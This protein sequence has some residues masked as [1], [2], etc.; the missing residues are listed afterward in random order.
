[1]IDKFLSVNPGLL[2]GLNKRMGKILMEMDLF[3]GM[4]VDIEVVW[5]G[6]AYIQKLDYLGVSFRCSECK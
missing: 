1:V 3:K 4:S 5:N 6:E 2:T